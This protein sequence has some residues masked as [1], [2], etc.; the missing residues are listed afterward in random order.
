MIK[1]I[2]MKKNLS[3]V[4]RAIR[5]MIA[6]I[7]AGLYFSEVLTGTFGAVMLIIAVIFAITGMISFCPIYYSLGIHSNSRMTPSR[8]KTN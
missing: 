1:L 6:L 8:V 3:T 7:I 2:K 4:D 5:I